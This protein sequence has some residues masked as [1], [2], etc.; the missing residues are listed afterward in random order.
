M[1][2]KQAANGYLTGQCLIAMPGMSD[3]RFEK[4][5]IYMCAHN[6]EGAMGL[7]VNRLFGSVNFSDLMSQLDVTGEHMPSDKPVHY[8]GPVEP[9][10]GFVLHS[11]DYQHEGTMLVDG[12]VALTATFDVLRAI[13]AGAGPARAMMA[14]GYAGWSAGQLDDELQANGW[15]TVAADADLLWDEN[16]E[17]KWER[18]MAKIG[19]DPRMLTSDAGHA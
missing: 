14:L 11:A 4:T 7:V 6:A 17:S 19:I 13:A 16:L 5:V 18:A 3:P 1:T 12:G 10:R 9:G 8:G 15:L 2:D